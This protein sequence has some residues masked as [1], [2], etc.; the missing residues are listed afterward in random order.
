MCPSSAAIIYGSGHAWLPFTAAIMI[1]KWHFAAVFVAEGTTL[2]AKCWNQA[3][4]REETELSG[5][6]TE[7]AAALCLRVNAK[8]ESLDFGGF[9][10]LPWKTCPCYRSVSLLFKGDMVLQYSFLRKR[11]H[12][13]TLILFLY[14][15]SGE[16]GASNPKDRELLWDTSLGCLAVLLETNCTLSL[17]P[18]PFPSSPSFRWAPA[19][20]GCFRAPFC[21]LSQR[22]ERAT[23]GCSPGWDRHLTFCWRC[24]NCSR[25]QLQCSVL[26]AHR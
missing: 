8:L 20:L 4:P 22:K 14:K 9:W 26:T 21:A 10:V 16:E 2:V 1:S 13:P 24:M 25:K 23:A 17:G 12:F 3:W 11:R 15:G 18:Q 5:L 7:S 19:H 6:T